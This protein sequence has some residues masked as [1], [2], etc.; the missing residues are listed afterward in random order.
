M[1]NEQ[2]VSVPRAEI[3][4]AAERFARA[5]IF[6]FSSKLHALLAQPAA[7]CQGEPVAW[8]VTD[9]N[10]DSY[11]AYDKQT[12][13][14]KP[15]YT[16][17]DAGEVERLRELSVTKIM[18][19]IVPGA[20]G[21][22]HEVYA[23][24]VQDVVNELGQMD[25]RIELL[26]A[27]LAEAHALLR[28]LKNDCEKDPMYVGPSWIKRIDAALS[29]SAEPSAPVAL[30]GTCKGYGKHQDG[31]SGTD[32]DGRCPNI[33]ECDCDDSERMPQYRSSAPVE[34]DE[35][36]DFEADVTRRFPGTLLARSQH[37]P[38]L[39][40]NLYVQSAWDAW[41]ARAALERNPTD[42][43]PL[44]SV[45]I[46]MQKRRDLYAD[47]VKNAAIPNPGDA[48]RL[49]ELDVQIAALKEVLS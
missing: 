14:D 20:D 44:H 17:A 35:R 11:F 6:D 41:Q 23:K 1:N 29:A 2:M 30:C 9:M 47:A 38:E 42:S 37:N 33:V 7:Q 45:L 12:P 43:T 24:S 5:Q 36:A 10:G 8:I 15:L 4:A 3:E 16:H 25:D 34:R 22:G 18:L 28:V 19:G 46:F 40:L 13:S 27:Q 39:Y 21:M 32:E 31:D 26:R 48:S 49:D